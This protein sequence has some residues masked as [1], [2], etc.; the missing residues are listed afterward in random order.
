MEKK[1]KTYEEC[2][3]AVGLTPGTLPDV[4]MLPEEY[5]KSLIADFQLSII[6]KAHNDGWEPN[7]NDDDE[8]KYNMAPF[9]DAN[10]E[11]PTGFGF[12][13]SYC[14]SWFA[15]ADCGSRHLLKSRELAIYIQDQFPEICK[16]HFLLK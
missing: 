3:A 4:S 11:H 16:A 13:L 5:R 14:D 10:E 1:L 9:I 8:W 15:Y 7:F 12:S 2:E 6:C